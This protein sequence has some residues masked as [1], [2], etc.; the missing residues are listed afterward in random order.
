ML[1][2]E[3]AEI[4]YLGCNIKDKILDFYDTRDFDVDHRASNLNVGGCESLG[5]GFR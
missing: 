3:N 2:V 5:A 1:G 4:R